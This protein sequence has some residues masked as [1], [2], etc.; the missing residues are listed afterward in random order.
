MSFSAARD[1]PAV[2]TPRE[3]RVDVVE[4][5]EA[6]DV[7]VRRLGEVEGV[8]GARED[9]AAP[10]LSIPLKANVI[11]QPCL[12]VRTQRRL[13][14]FQNTCTM[15]NEDSRTNNAKPCYCPHL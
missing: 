14:R 9:V 11:V 6:V 5:Q 4:R 13:L 2:R 10:Q 1:K 7:V 3:A 12:E 8:E 15:P